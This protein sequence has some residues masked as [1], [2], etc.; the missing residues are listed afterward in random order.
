MSASYLLLYYSAKILRP[1]LSIPS[2]DKE[3]ISAKIESYEGKKKEE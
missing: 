3:S 2:T 1:L